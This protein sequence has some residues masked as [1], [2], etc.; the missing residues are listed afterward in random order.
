MGRGQD[1]YTTFRITDEHGQRY[2]E[3]LSLAAFVNGK[4]ERDAVVGSDGE[5]Q[6]LWRAPARGDY[7]VT[8]EVP[9][10]EGVVRLGL[11][12]LGVG[13]GRYEVVRETD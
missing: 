4:R 13:L 3:G 9:T 1:L 11:R 6:W 5:V 2:P 7:E 12:Q 8:F 10:V